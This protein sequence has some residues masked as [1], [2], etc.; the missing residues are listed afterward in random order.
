MR[1]RASLAWLAAVALAA[2]IMTAVLGSW[3]WRLA[4]E[5]LTLSAGAGAFMSLFV[6]AALAGALPSLAGIALLR[7]LRAPR[8]WGDGVLGALLAVFA[9]FAAMFAMGALSGVVDARY[10]LAAIA[11]FGWALGLSGAAAGFV[12]WRLAGRPRPPY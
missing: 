3:D 12:Y 10:A 9:G 11:M 4:P 7:R 2:L 6:M 5:S 8:P 1:A